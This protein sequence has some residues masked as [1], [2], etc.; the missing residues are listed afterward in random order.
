MQ[1]PTFESKHFRRSSLRLLAIAAGAAG[2]SGLWPAA[3]GYEAPDVP[4]PARGTD[5]RPLAPFQR[6]DWEAAGELNICVAARERLRIEADPAVL[7]QVI[8]EVRDGTL[9]IAFAAGRIR[10]D[11]PIRFQLQVRGLDA[12]RLAGSGQV[13]LDGL[14]AERLRLH[15]T[16][17]V[18]VRGRG[19]TVGQLQVRCE[20][21][22]S[23]ELDGGSAGQ[24]T[25][26]LAGACDYVADGLPSRD[27]TVSITGSGRAWVSASQ[28]L[29]ASI[30]GSGEIG[31]RGDPVLTREVTGAGSILRLARKP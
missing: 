10:T 18:A 14:Q 8:S 24:Q 11:R 21:A 9:R 13:T 1:V 15:S 17:S 19:L 28:R 7:R 20:G 2:L 25:V 22:S 6:V 29:H 31:Y 5:D 23:F 4:D 26:E 30:T 12:I 3:R 27:V 16:S